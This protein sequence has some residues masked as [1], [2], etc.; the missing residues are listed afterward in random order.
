MS[1]V[2]L[3]GVGGP[4]G[5]ER[6]PDS[7]GWTMPSHRASRGQMEKLG[8]PWRGYGGHLDDEGALEMDSAGDVFV[9][10]WD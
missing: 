10:W 8:A 9:N 3:A 1:W 4:V 7:G 5:R 2:W 6:I